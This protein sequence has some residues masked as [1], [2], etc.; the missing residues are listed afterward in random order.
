MGKKG[1]AVWLSWVLAVGLAVVL[2]MFVLNWS[3]GLVTT[4]K[5]DLVE[6]ADLAELCR[7]IAFRIDD[8]CQ[9]T[10]TLNMNITNNNNLK[11]DS[12]IVRII[13]IYGLPQLRDA[14][15]TLKPGDAKQIKVVKQGIIKHVE[16]IPAVF[17]GDKRLACQSRKVTSETV[18]IC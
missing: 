8:S 1:V 2:G 7:D 17:S 11:I 13:D 6:R 12:F 5:E 4:Q 9:N 15:V 14:N 16:I 18:R 3:R 10:Q